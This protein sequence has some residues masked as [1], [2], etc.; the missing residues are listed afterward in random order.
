MFRFLKASALLLAVLLAACGSNSN[1]AATSANVR[2]VNATQSAGLTGTLNGAVDFSKVPAGSA[3][4]Y[5]TVPAGNYTITVADSSG[6]LVSSTQTLGLG[7]GQTYTL[8]SYDRDGAV[9][10]TVFTENQIAPPAGYTTFD[11]TNLSPDSGPLDVY[12]VAVG[13]TSLAGLTPT[14]QF[15]QAGVTQIGTSLVAGTYAVFATATGNSNDIRF[16]VPSLTLSNG[17]ILMMAFTSTPG[18]AL[19]NGVLLNQGGAVQFAPNTNARVRVMSALPAS[20]ASLVATTV[21]GVQFS[22]VFSPNPSSY[23]LVP[24]GTTSYSISVSG[25]PVGTLPAAT[26]ATGGDYTILVYGSASSPSVSVFTDNN[27][28]PV[29]GQLKLRLVNAA[30]SSAGGLSMYDNGVQVANSVA[31]GAA[32]AYL[33]VT[34]SSVSQLELIEPSVAPVTVATSLLGT[35][36]AVYTVFVID[37]T[38]TPYLIRD[39]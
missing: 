13:T 6:T 35:A 17:Q 24:G 39:R 14:F 9:Y 1:T 7:S 29:G 4:A 15:A 8:L 25:T 27:Q 37:S 12:V 11:I 18:G 5:A 2:L 10:T 23:T 34:P 3:S 33:G 22:S 20:G 38:L 31:Y 26:F 19:V 28:V 32:S 36:G 21:G 16:S 30:V